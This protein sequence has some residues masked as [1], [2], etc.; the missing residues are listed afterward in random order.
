MSVVFNYVPGSNLGKEVTEIFM[1][2]LIPAGTMQLRH[3]EIRLD[4]PMPFAGD[5]A[6]ECKPRY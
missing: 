5:C 1:V 2:F 3:P 4:C 6:Y